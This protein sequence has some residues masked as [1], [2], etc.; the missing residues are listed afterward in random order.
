MVRWGRR[1]KGGREPRRADVIIRESGQ[2]W[3]WCA[4]TFGIVEASQGEAAQPVMP[5]A[6]DEAGRIDGDGDRVEKLLQDLFGDVDG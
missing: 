6:S 5:P 1:D 2:G 3:P 4:G